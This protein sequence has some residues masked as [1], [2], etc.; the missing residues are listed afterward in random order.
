MI[1]AA[2]DR[3]Y[4]FID[5]ANKDVTPFEFADIQYWND[6]TALCRTEYDS[7]VLYNIYDQTI[8]LDE[9]T[10]FHTISQSPKERIILFTS[11]DHFGIASNVNGLIINPSFT[12]IVNI[13]NINDPLYFAEKYIPEAEFF[14]VIY[15]NKI[16]E[17]LRKQVFTQE[18]YGNIYCE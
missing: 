13:G 12:D 6:S 15:Y 18:E 4:G 2:R 10:S 11:E 5:H 1:I 17:I 7:W 8:V 3:L 16:G 14:V 9:I